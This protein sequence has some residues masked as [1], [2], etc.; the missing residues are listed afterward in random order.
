HMLR[1]GWLYT[2]DVA[3][4]DEDGYFTIVDRI[5]DLIIVG[6]ANVYPSEIEDV[7]LAHP[8]VAEAA[9]VGMPDARKG[10]LPR[11]YVVLREGMAATT[12]DIARHCQ[13]NLAHYKWPAQIEIRTELPKSMIGKVLRRMLT[14]GAGEEPASEP[15]AQESPAAR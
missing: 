2:G 10:E 3:T 11:A 6:G 4:M 15:P 14:P 5:K 1:D 7:L 8:A 9:V 12:D 13:E